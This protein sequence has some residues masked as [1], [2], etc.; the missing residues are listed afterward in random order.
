[1]LVHFYIPPFWYGVGIGVL[2]M[3][4]FWALV[5]LWFFRKAKSEPEPPEGSESEEK[6]S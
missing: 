4:I 5:L 2:G 3:H 6:E 1:M